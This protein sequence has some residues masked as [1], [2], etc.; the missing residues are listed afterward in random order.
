MKIG[1]AFINNRNHTF[2]F[3]REIQRGKNKGK[4]ECNLTKGRDRS[5]KIRIGK[6]VVLLESQV[7]RWE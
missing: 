5:G 6:R 1:Q 7:R 2:V 4:M 3:N